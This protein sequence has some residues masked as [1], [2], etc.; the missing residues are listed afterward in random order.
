M[1]IKNLVDIQDN[2]LDMNIVGRMLAV[3]SQQ[4]EKFKDATVASDKQNTP[5]LL[6]KKVRSAKN[7]ILNR[8]QQNLTDVHWGNI[9]VNVFIQGI[10]NYIKNKNCKY[11]FNCSVRD[12]ILL[13]YEKGDHYVYHVDHGN[14]TPRTLSSIFLLNNDYEGGEVCFTDPSGNEEFCI[15]VKPSRLIVWPSNFMFPH[16]IKPVTKGTRYSVVSWAL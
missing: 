7:V 14:T 4:P 8:N 16:S 9:L 10:D 11:L 6:D 3:Y 1:E 15:D 5:G 2:M 12:M 13:K